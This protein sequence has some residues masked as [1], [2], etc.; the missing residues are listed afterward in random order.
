MKG[1]NDGIIR[2]KRKKSC[3]ICGNEL[4]LFSSLPVEDGE[5]CSDCEKMLRGQF[6]ITEY[7]KQRWGTT[8]FDR[9]DYVLKTSD[10][11]KVMTV[12]EIEEMIRSMKEEQAQI[13]ENVGSNYANVAKVDNCFS[14][15]PKAL[16]VG[17]KRAKAYKNRIVA[18][19]QIITGEF[20][21]DD[22]VTVTTNGK[23][24]TTTI[25]DV[26]E[27]SNSSTFETMLASNIRKHNVE[28]GTSAWILLDLMEDIGEGSLIQK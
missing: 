11:L 18:T 21:K 27:C 25:L 1:D 8:G 3:P 4:K 2:K 13:I 12:A 28:A 24:I 22:T 10:P 15:A 20:A 16:E 14:I 7:W 17:M 23:N 9:A 5:I 19:S 26:I 6:N